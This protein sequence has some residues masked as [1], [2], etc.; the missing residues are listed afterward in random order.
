MTRDKFVVVTGDLRSSRRLKN[1]VKIQE[2]L[3]NTLK[4]INNTFGEDIVAKFVIVGGDGFQ[5]MILSPECLFDLYY[6]LFEQ[7]GHRFYIG[8][9]IGSISTHMSSVIGEMDGEVFY[10][11]SKALNEAKKG[12]RWVVF[13]GD[14]DGDDLISSS[15]NLMADVMWHWTKRQRE[16]VMLYR[17]ETGVDSVANKLEVTD[18]AIYK[19]LSSSRYKTLKAVE[20]SLRDFLEQNWLKIKNRP[21]M[22]EKRGV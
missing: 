4:I 21:K 18:K 16:V 14:W 12:R 2:K 13:K 20:S 8:I 10:K 6:L 22:V 11:S 5:G 9:G 15:W 17:R 3:K 19:I 1:R 7:I